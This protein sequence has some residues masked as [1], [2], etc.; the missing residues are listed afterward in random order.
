MMK[1]FNRSGFIQGLALSLSVVPA[2][3]APVG[4]AA[5]LSGALMSTFASSPIEIVQTVPPIVMLT[6]SMDHQYF[7]KAYNDFTDLKGDG[8][9]ER[10]YDDTFN[11]Y[12]YFHAHRCYRYTDGTTSFAA[13][14]VAAGTNKHYCDGTSSNAWSG[15]FL[16]WATMTRMDIVRK[17]LYGGYRSTDTAANTT[18]ERAHLPTDA[19]SFVKYYNGPDLALLTPFDTV[20]TDTTNGGNENGIDDADEGISICNTSYKSSGSSQGTTDTTPSVLPDPAPMMRVV[21]KNYA[22]WAAHER[23]QCRYEDENNQDSSHTNSNQPAA[24]GIKASAARPPRTDTLKTPGDASDH[25]VRVQVCQPGS[26]DSNDNLENCKAYGSNLK[27]EGLLQRYGLDGQIQFGLIT[28]SYAKNISGGV[29]RKK[30]GALT[31]EVNI[32]DGTFIAKT[33]TQPGIIRTLNAVRI[34]GYNYANGVYFGGGSGDNCPFQLTDIVEGDCRSWGNPMSEIY[35]EALRYFTLSGASRA[36]TA[37]FNADDTGSINGLVQDSWTTDPLGNNNECAS[38]NA[39]VFNASVDSY[40][41]NQT[42]GLDGIFT[43][44]AKAATKAVG[45]GEGITGHQFFIGRTGANTNEICTA[46]QINDLGDAFGICPEA[47]TV[48]GS[49]HMAGLAY[50]AHTHDIRPTL[51]GEQKVRTFGVTLATSTPIIDVP[52]GTVAAATKHVRILP[53]YR[54]RKGGNNLNEALNNPTQDGAGQLVDFKIITPHTEVASAASTTPQTGT[55]HFFGKVYINWEDSE[56]GGDYDQDM[57]GVIE[58]RVNTNVSP[59]TITVKTNGISASGGGAQQLFGYVLSGTNIDGFHAHNGFLGAN[60]TDPT[61]VLGCTNCQMSNFGG[62]PPPGQTGARSVTYTVSDTPSAGILETPLFYAAKWGGFD[63]IDGDNTPN[64]QAEFDTKDIHGDVVA[65]GDGIPDNY[66]FVTNPSALEESLST[67]FNTILERVSSGTSAAVVASDQQGNGAI[68]QAVYDPSKKDAT[69]AR[70]E[71]KWIGTLDALWVDSAGLLRE[72]LGTK[73]KLD[74]YQTDQVVDIFYDE[75]ARR[76]R[77]RRH[78]SSDPAKFVDSGTSLAELSDLNT[79]WNARD[80]LADLD[81]ATIATQRAYTSRA[82]TGR[83]ILTWIDTNTDGVPNNGEVINF[84]STNID[85]SN[86]RWLDMPTVAEAQA[87]V[88]WTRGKNAGMT[89]FRARKLD[90]AGDGITTAHGFDEIM[91]LGDIVHSN[92]KSVSVPTQAYDVFDNDA[93]YTPFFTKYRNRRQVVYVGA[94]DGMIHAFNAGFFDPVAKEFKL[95]P[96][97]EV[98]HPLG[99]ELWAYVPKNL[100]PQLQWTARKDYS[101]VFYIDNSIRT[102]EAKIFDPADPDHPNGWGTVLVAAMSLGGGSDATGITIDTQGDGLGAANTDNNTRD[103]VKTKSAVVIMDVTNP[104][105]PPKLLAELTPPNLQFTTS[106]PALVSIATPNANNPNKWFLVVG[107]GPTDLGSISYVSGTPPNQ[108][109]ASLFVYDLSKLNLGLDDVAASELNGLQRTMPLTTPNVFI[110]DLVD[111]D[112][113]FNLRTDAVYFGTVGASSDD[114]AANQGSL[115]RLSVGEAADP[116]A[117][118]DPFQ[119]VSN[120]NQP[121]GSAPTLAFDA[122]LRRWVVA[123]SGRYLTTG[124]RTTVRKQKLIGV[125]DKNPDGAGGVPAAPFSPQ[126]DLDSLIDVSNARVFS[127]GGVALDGSTTTTTTFKD[128]GNSIL[129]VGGWQ[130]NFTLATGSPAERGVRG[131]SVAGGIAFLPGFTPSS[132]LCNSDGSTVQ[133]GLSFTTGTGIPSGVFDQIPCSSCSHGRVES[134]PNP[135][136]H[137]GPGDTAADWA[138]RRDV[139]LGGASNVV[140]HAGGGGGGG[141]SSHGTADIYTSYSTAA[142]SAIKARLGRPTLDGE[143]SWR[144]HR[145]DQ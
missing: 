84:V 12:G 99:T 80:A 43:Q 17:I 106:N 78:T 83:H 117:W 19:H 132:A 105:V 63:D 91:R 8:K 81:D 53:A 86:F 34:Y 44:T 4:Q 144:E 6:M 62:A 124:D 37:A 56:Q 42:D 69:A 93:S 9:V 45:D 2:L 36:P 94:N 39:V 77:I 123:A 40:D 60:F 87:L 92:P 57:W 89:Q 139:G 15:N 55:G 10:T 41:D 76:A 102:F 110:G 54:L 88:D 25:I 72:D 101:H 131:V 95:S 140:L 21:R 121:F 109:F 90:Y 11:Y 49:Y 129:A 67:I 107:S 26:F 85:P 100:L 61:G 134:P 68:F 29:L 122:H 64:L 108:R 58:Y 13:V 118:L 96:H 112:F 3:W 1:F 5:N 50:Y 48:R 27:P 130:R 79:I 142:I 138:L 35:L 22:L 137:T 141:D 46:K 119:L 115:F 120:L 74:D 14:G 128:L 136:K 75:T 30:V 104:E 59:A 20:K 111:A 18:L 31:D 16:N 125:I 143:I 38:L 52:I 127:D 82:D 23:Y 70:N 51:T 33:G 98:D 7:F 71:V 126:A 133:Y 114:N 32:A 73:G 65:G 66:F 47:P 113:N 97:G 24:S 28:G 103:D 145:D 135:Y 116:A